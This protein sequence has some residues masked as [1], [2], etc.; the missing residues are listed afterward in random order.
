[1]HNRKLTN[2]TVTTRFVVKIFGESILLFIRCCSGSVPQNYDTKENSYLSMSCTLYPQFK[3]R[4]YNWI[5]W[6]R[7]GLNHRN[8][9]RN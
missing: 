3:D 7:E 2:S 5:A 9:A 1:M 4:I 8:I 6:E